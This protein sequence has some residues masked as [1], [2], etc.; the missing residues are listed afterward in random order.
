MTPIVRT[1]L[2]RID[3]PPAEVFPLLCPVREAEWLDGWREHCEVLFT[4]S[5][6]AERDCVFRTPAGADE[7]V[8]LV[9]LHDAGARR[10][11]F[12]RV[13]PGL[14]A[15]TLR[16]AVLPDGPD[17]S[18]VHVEY[19]VHALSAA[20]APRVAERWEEAAFRA[21]QEHWEAS[22]NHFLRTGAM[23]PAR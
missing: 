1:H 23:L 8:W 3:A 9:T 7:M 12:A 10:V 6:V 5:G 18:F 4:R 13:V 19:T 14:E 11:E 21:N 15:G 16:L 17:R 22:M 20:A 2:Q